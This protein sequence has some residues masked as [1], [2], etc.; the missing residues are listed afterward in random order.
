MTKKSGGIVYLICD[1]SQGL[2]KI[3]MTKGKI[4]KRIKA[5]QTGNATELFVIHTH[6][7]QYPFCVE[8]MLHRRFQHK[9]ILNEWFELTPEDVK[10]FS[11]N[12][13][14]CEETIETMK[15]NPFFQKYLK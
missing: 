13:M 2:Y 11:D 10:Q 9:Q 3:G 14:Q 4:E 1:A 8:G 12:C 15:D 7:T 5:L 6:R